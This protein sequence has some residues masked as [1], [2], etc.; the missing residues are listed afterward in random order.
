MS[1]QWGNRI[2]ISIFGESHGA[3]IG[4]V[5][6]GLPAGIAIDW[7]EVRAQMA[8]RAPGKSL[9]ATA[10]QEGDA[11]DV[12]SGYYDGHTT[13]TPLCAM[14][15]NKDHQS[16]SYRPFRRTPRPGHADYPA[17]LRYGGYQDHRGGGH[18]SGRLTAPLVLAGA[19]ARQMVASRGVTIGAHMASIGDVVDQKLGDD[20]T[21]DALHALATKP[22]AVV[23]D[24][25]G[26]AMKRAIQQ[27][28]E[29]GD[30]LGGVIT[31][32]AVGLPAGL[33]SPIFDAVEC[34]LASLLFGIPAVKGVSF[35][36]G[37]DVAKMRGSEANDPW[38]IQDGVVKTATNHNGGI[39]GGITTGMPL[40]VNVAIKPT[41][42]IAMKQQTVDL[43]GMASSEVEIKGRHDPCI[44]PR[45]IPVVEAAVALAVLDAWMD[46]SDWSERHESR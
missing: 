21:A 28:K 24:N 30:S 27:A 18:F 17:M 43:D 35:G 8:R 45:A 19:I 14:I 38:S 37:F 42:S 34:S 10:R 23:D 20:V 32:C 39:I 3:A 22:F 2:K 7:D 13:G 31:C 5:M 29:D 41:P 9:W 40:V 1:S 16:D 26:E 11:F 6:D 36:S 33:G 15:R 44:V 12:V 4:V 25:Q 46:Q